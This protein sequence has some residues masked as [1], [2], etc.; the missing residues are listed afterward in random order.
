MGLFSDEMPAF[1]GGL[2]DGRSQGRTDLPQYPTTCVAMDRFVPGTS[3][4]LSRCPGTN[5]LRQVGSKSLLPGGPP[6]VPA[7]PCV[8]IPVYDNSVAVLYVEESAG[9]LYELKVALYPISTPF[10]WRR[11]NTLQVPASLS[12][13]S[14]FA[15]DVRECRWQCYDGFTIV[16]H[17]LIPPFIIDTNGGS[18][19]TVSLLDITLPPLRAEDNRGVEITAS[20][21]SGSPSSPITLTATNLAFTPQD[22][23][24][25]GDAGNTIIGFRSIPELDYDQW[26]PSTAYSAGDAVWSPS[27]ETPG[28]IN[29]YRAQSAGNSGTRAPGH[30]ANTESDGSLNWY[31]IHSQYG[32]FRITNYIN[33]MEAEGYPVG[34]PEIPVS[35]LSGTKRWARSEWN[36]LYGYPRTVCRFQARL[37]FGGTRGSPRGVWGSRQFSL[38]NFSTE[39]TAPSSA[40][41]FAIDGQSRNEITTLHVSE[42]IIVGTSANAYYARGGD[43]S[44]ITPTNIL[45]SEIG[46]YSSAGVV[47]AL[48]SGVAYADFNGRSI[49]LTVL[50]GREQQRV[51][52]DI[53][54]FYRGNFYGYDES[55]VKK[56]R[57]TLKQGG[58]QILWAAG[59]QDELVGVT[60]D[61]D[62][63][64]LAYHAHSIGKRVVDVLYMEGAYQGETY[65]LVDRD[66]GS[67]QYSLE[68]IPAPDGRRGAAFLDQAVTLE[69]ASTDTAVNVAHLDGQV[70]TVVADG[71]I[72]GEFLVDSLFLNF[73]ET[74]EADLLEVG[75]PFTSSVKIR[76]PPEGS[77]TGS[78]FGKRAQIRTAALDLLDTGPGVQVGIGGRHVDLPQLQR[79]G[80][81]IMG[82]TIPEFTGTTDK[83]AIPSGHDDRQE[84]E[85]VCTGVRDANIRAIFMEYEVI[86]E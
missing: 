28:R 54:A 25:A 82:Q 46:A 56:Y 60:V 74:I 4:V 66:N 14:V 67:N 10:A 2:W 52:L 34:Y 30:D 37:V 43:L 17:P 73:G 29:V 62:Q 57:L 84:L 23:S 68:S 1:V 50:G 79:A 27:Y 83:V 38:T 70:V 13:G 19:L 47:A 42:G 20:A 22:I 71:A 11:I 33:L 72:V 85:V 5:F 35:A 86:D 6:D 39:T 15:H 26:T 45:V 24:A 55:L 36:R 7:N 48:G 16:T 58:D 49:G 21:T 59:M 77:R 63:G 80:G 64:V 61:A 3:G 81:Q 75:I 53:S 12:L 9:P 44:A 78:S 41:A 65:I 40:F 31:F 51:N 18:F 69:D 8:M 32:Y 76:R